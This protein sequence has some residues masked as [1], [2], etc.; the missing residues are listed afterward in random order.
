M[1]C[2][3]ALYGA[4][5]ASQAVAVGGAINFGNVIRRFGNNINLNG[6]NVTLS[7][8]GYY[9]IDTNFTFTA[10]AGTATI[11][12]YKNGV[13]IP[14]ATISRTT[15]ADTI[16]TVSIPAIVREVCCAG[17]AITAVLSGVAGTFTDAAIVVEKI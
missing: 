1:S 4:N 17:S 2:K 7:G 15:A 11:T 6:P 10:A 5:T 13:P 16:Y 12:L 3:S 14:G 8:A 9:D